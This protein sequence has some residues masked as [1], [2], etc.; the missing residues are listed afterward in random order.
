MLLAAFPA[1]VQERFDADDITVSLMTSV[2]AASAIASRFLTAW[3][4]RRID[5]RH[6]LLVSIA[7]AVIFTALYA[8]AWSIDSLLLWRIGFGIGFGMASTI[9]PTLVSAVIPGNRIGEGI[10]YFG[11]STSL[12]MSIGPLTGLNI[13]DAYGFP[14]L[15][16]LG[17]GVAMLILPVLLLTRALPA[18]QPAVAHIRAGS[19]PRPPFP[20]QIAIPALLNLLLG[21]TYSGLL[22]FIALYGMSA[23]LPQAG[24]FF[25]F[26]VVAILI[27][28]PLAGRWFDRR[29]PVVVLIPAALSLGGGLLVLSYA[30]TMP[31]L[32]AA[33]LLY[34]AGFG[35]IQPTLQAWMLRVSRPEQ[36]GTANSM[37][38]NSADLGIAIGSFA[39]GAL[40]SVSD[41][42]IMYRCS[43]A[44]SLLF[45]LAVLYAR[46]PVAAVATSPSIDN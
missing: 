26:N 23:G 12:A 21:F 22:S 15:V 35:S 32:T 8:S 17:T 28:R 11:L 36:Q 5:R 34:G 45:L 10:A 9:I 14:T 30:T 25:L 7:L 44:L 13:L 46:R 29:G 43:A 33:A 42:G 4:L 18:L 6:L 2:F 16:W 41:Y 40:A 1:Y 37:F 31:M 20:R 27:V 24:L 39:L 3:L 38:Y 19:A